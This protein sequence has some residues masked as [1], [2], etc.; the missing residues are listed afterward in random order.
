MKKYIPVILALF[1]A[2]S[3]NLDKYP[4]SETAADAY[5]KNTSSVNNLVIGAY[6]GLYGVLYYE[7][8]M[9]E[10]RSD[11]V[12]MRV[13]NSSSADTKLLEQLDQNVPVTANDWVQDYWDKSYVVVNRANTVLENLGVVTD[14]A[15][16]AQFEGEALFLRS[17]MYFNIVRLW[18]P[19]FIVTRT[20]GAQ[21]A[22]TMQRSSVDEVYDLIEGDLEKIVKE[23]LLPASMD[24]ADLGRA[25]IK[26]A[27]V[28]LAKVYMTRYSPADEKY[29]EAK[30]LL[31]EV[32]TAKGNPS[33]A[34]QLEPY[35][36]VFSKNNEL[37]RE[38]IFAVR[39]KAGKL[40]IGSPFS[41]LFGPLNNGGNVVMGS[42]KHYDY[43]SDN[44]IAAYEE[45]DLRKDVTLRESYYNATTGETVTGN[46]ARFT[47]KFID[48]DMTS[49]YDGENDWPVIRVA[50]VL[51]LYVEACNELSGPSEDI[52][53]YLNAV[54]GRA[55]LPGYAESA[56]G[57]KFALREAVRRERRVELAME[58]HR[59]YDL[60]RW[61]TAVSTVN[62]FYISEPFFGAYDYQVKPIED[63]QILLPIPVSVKNINRDVAQ[64]P[65]Y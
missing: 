60:V 57:T 30:K 50:D 44:L 28:M 31:G 18:G 61:G 48:P 19:A 41:T 20:I 29:T 6:N 15:K 21:E 24:A 36:S 55:G 10:L 46:A 58:N 27:K 22:R 62:G 40:G 33:S 8:A 4:Y 14:E 43:P 54:R 51:L 7:W 56:V 13:N 49:E 64:N 12:R 65:G 5:V 16:K 32:I 59:W 42:P 9:T 3:C 34:E 37:N 63:W 11:N 2:V 39:Y 26:A 38:I 52:L 23:K 35:E 25:D 45:G 1:A 47:N 17:W 53:A